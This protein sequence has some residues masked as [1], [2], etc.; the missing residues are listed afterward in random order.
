MRPE[1]EEE[2]HSMQAALLTLA[3]LTGGPVDVPAPGSAG[4]G[5]AGPGYAGPGYAAQAS[6]ETGSSFDTGASYGVETEYLPHT[7]IQPQTCYAPRFGCYYGGD[8]YMH[9][10]PAFHGY[11]WRQPYNY[12]NVFDYPWHAGLHEPTSLFAYNVEEQAPPQAGGARPLP[13]GARP[14]PPGAR[15]VSGKE[16]RGVTR[17][18][19][20]TTM[21]VTGHS[22]AR[23][24]KTKSPRAIELEGRLAQI[25]DELEQSE[26]Q[27]IAEAEAMRRDVPE[28]TYTRQAAVVIM[29]RPTIGTLVA[30]QS[31]TAPSGPL[32]AAP[33]SAPAEITPAPV[34]QTTAL[35]AIEAPATEAAPAVESTP[36]EPAPVLAPAAVTTKRIDNAGG[37]RAKSK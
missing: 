4:P 26:Q 23:P 18:P 1:P 10:Y 31:Y 19:G 24:I 37:W 2:T 13:P 35:P 8:R 28:Q 29:P 3:L 6:Y 30:P 15:P 33:A 20:R 16:V 11:Y 25:E 32:M 36:S 34:A 27:A 14:L 12:R 7:C 5:Y 17:K 22:G 9:R 21:A